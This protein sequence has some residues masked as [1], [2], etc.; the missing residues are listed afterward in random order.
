MNYVVG[1]FGDIVSGLPGAL[2]DAGLADKVKVV[3]YSQNAT[4][5][6]YLKQGQ[7]QAIIGFPGPEDMWQVADTF[8]RIFAGVSFEANQNDLPSWIITKDTV[9]STTEFYPLV[10]DYQAQYK[11]LWGIS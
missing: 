8:A 3:T 9:P 1:V 11:A 6:S 2:A 7:I 4:L 10:E 5:S